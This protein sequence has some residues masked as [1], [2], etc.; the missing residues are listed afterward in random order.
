MPWNARYFN[1][2]LSVVSDAWDT[3]TKIIHDRINDLLRNEIYNAIPNTYDKPRIHLEITEKLWGVFGIGVFA[4]DGPLDPS[5]EE[6]L[7]ALK[8]RDSALN[9][10]LDAKLAI[11]E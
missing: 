1:G 6:Q 3:D 4:V 7:A 10:D 5:L 2:L 9:A 8:A 11:V